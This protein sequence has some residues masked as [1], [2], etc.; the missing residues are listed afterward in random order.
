[1][2]RTLG[3]ESD[4][5]EDENENTQSNTYSDSDSDME[6]QEDQENPSQFSY[7]SFRAPPRAPPPA[8]QTRN[9]LN[10]YTSH[11]YQSSSFTSS[12]WD[13][14]SGSQRGRESNKRS[15]LSTNFFDT[16]PR[17]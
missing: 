3:S 12:A 9:V 8:T 1:M 6:D 13:F 2:G 5:D 10:Y 15:P 16:L 7:S 4:D 17:Q 14:A 11:S